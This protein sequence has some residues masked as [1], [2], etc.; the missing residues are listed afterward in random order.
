MAARHVARRHEGAALGAHVPERTHLPGEAAWLVGEWRT[1]GEREY[2][3]T[4]HAEGT[5]LR[6]LA[7]AIKARWVCEQAHQ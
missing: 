7:T 1:S 5:S 6:A 4:N 3:L 2:Y